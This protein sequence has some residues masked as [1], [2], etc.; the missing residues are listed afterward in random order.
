MTT[1]LNKYQL[2]LLHFNEELMEMDVSYEW[3]TWH[4]QEQFKPDHFLN[5]K[6]E[7]LKQLTH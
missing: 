4:L 1:N 2:N 6:A 5:E 7:L 3:N